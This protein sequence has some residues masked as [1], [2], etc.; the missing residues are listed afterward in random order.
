[1]RKYNEQLKRAKRKREDGGRLFEVEEVEPNGN[2]QHPETEVQQEEVIESQDVDETEEELELNE[3]ERY[4]LKE[5][6]KKKLEMPEKLE[7]LI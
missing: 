6:L 3:G 7:Q 5:L 4:I 1:M 2:A